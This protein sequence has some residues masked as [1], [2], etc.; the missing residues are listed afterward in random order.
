MLYALTGRNEFLR[1]EFVGQLK[2]LM[3]K[4]PLG[5]HNIEE[6]GPSARIADI[7]AAC[8]AV[9]FLCEKRMVI[10]R[11][12]VGASQ[13]H[14]ARRARQQRSPKTVGLSLADD[15]AHYVESLPLTTHLVLAE[16][17]AA[18]LEPVL[19][20]RPDAVKREFGP[21]RDDQLP[22][23]ATARARTYGARI[24]PRAAQELA[25]LV[26]A[27]LRELDAE[28]AKLATYVDQGSTIDVDDVHVLARGGGPGIF[29]FH[30]ALA[31]RRAGAALGYA[32]GLL[33]SG[34][35]P[36]EILAQM[37]GVVRRLL[38]AKEILSESRSLAREGPSFG[39]S[40]SPYA[41]QKLQRQAAP[42]AASDLDRAYVA[43]R[44]A[45]LAL[46]TG[47]CEPELAVELAVAGITGLNPERET[48]DRGADSW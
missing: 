8:S 3:Y 21:L 24:S 29:A 39:L 48:N 18:C 35:D 47:R 13:P 15:L 36:L 45:D 27:D 14:R 17:D 42:F 7:V 1:E 25:Q 22:A 31:E 5:E 26:G 30:D 16:E 23:W 46:K 6:L 9:P 28:I 37:N 32:R 33:A 10:V 4:L 41:L 34:H 44:D 19:A 38:I 12:A 2:A 20:A 40:A 43:L 11:G